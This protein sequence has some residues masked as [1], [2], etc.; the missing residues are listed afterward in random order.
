MVENRCSNSPIVVAAIPDRG[1][2]ATWLGPLAQLLTVLPEHLMCPDQRIAVSGE[3]SMYRILSRAVCRGIILLLLGKSHSAQDAQAIRVERHQ[4]I[5]AS[6]QE[7]LFR[8]R[9]SDAGK[10]L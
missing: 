2:A 8:A 5:G 3:L 4:R 10:S 9:I 7:Y 6:K 1:F